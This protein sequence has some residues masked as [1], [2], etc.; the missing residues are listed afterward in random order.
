S[1]DE[2]ITKRRFMKR[3]HWIWL[4]AIITLFLATRILVLFQAGSFWF[5]EAFSVH[6]ASKPLSELWSFLR[7]EHNPLAH[8]VLLHA[9][10]KVFGETELAARALSLVAGFFSLITVFLLGKNMFGIRA[11]LWSAFFFTL[12]TF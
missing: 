8:F 10:M 2:T 5:D 9:W 6:F 3:T 1:C 4:F 7:F 12:S 11:G